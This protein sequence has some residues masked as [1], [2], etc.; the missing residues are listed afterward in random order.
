MVI[1]LSV[2]VGQSAF[3]VPGACCKLI[4]KACAAVLAS[5]ESPSIDTAR[6]GAPRNANPTESAVRRAI[7]SKEVD[8]TGSSSLMRLVI[9][10]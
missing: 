2:P 5:V 7:K 3:A 8:A 1:E 9:H 4:V 6:L 10:V